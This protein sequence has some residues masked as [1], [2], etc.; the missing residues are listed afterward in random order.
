MS[1]R[2]G[3]TILYTSDFFCIFVLFDN[4]LGCVISDVSRTEESSP[5]CNR[6]ADDSLLF[7]EES[8]A[9]RGE[10]HQ[11]QGLK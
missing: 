5:E 9:I 8:L 10:V 2:K 7:T 3:K 6:C 4:L 1:N 11:V